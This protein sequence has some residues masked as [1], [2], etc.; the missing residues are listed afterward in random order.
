M[1]Q[2][3]F[4]RQ[5]EHPISCDCE[6]GRVGPGEM[7]SVDYHFPFSSIIENVLLYKPES[8]ATFCIMSTNYR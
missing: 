7:S 3:G 4:M 1:L 6:R 5:S 8:F 2:D